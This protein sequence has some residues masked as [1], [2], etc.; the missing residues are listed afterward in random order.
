[1]SQLQSC[2]LKGINALKVDCKLTKS[3][4]ISSSG[5]SQESFRG[6]VCRFFGVGDVEVHGTFLP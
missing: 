1:M 6:K 4:F 5:H 3:Q 2:N